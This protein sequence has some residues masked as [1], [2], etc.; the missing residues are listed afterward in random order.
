MIKNLTPS[1]L[2]SAALV[3][4][5][6]VWGVTFTVVD[7]ATDRLPAPD[8][9]VWR[10]G[11]AALVLRLVRRGRSSL[12]LLLRAR[13]VLLGVLLGAGFL[14]QAWALTY[15]DALRSGFLTGL[16]VVLAPVAAWL[17]FRERLGSATWAGVTLAAA[18]VGVLGFHA[19]GFGPGELLTLAS[20]AVWGL[21]LVLMSRWSE[22]EHAWGVARVQAAAVAALGGLVL[23]VRAARPG[24]STLL[25]LPTDGATWG[26]VLFLALVATAGT[27]VLLSWGQARVG[28]TRAAVILTLEPAVAGLTATIVGGAVTGRVLVG[29]VL[30][31]TAMLVVELA[32]RRGR[33][34]ADRSAG[35]VE[36]PRFVAPRPL[37]GGVG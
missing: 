29:G 26:S 8:L 13:S 3:A 19:G 28:A 9:V 4:V 7:G 30:L 34:A 31:L 21:H 37:A 11:L 2:P 23:V 32:G 10:F 5:A 36:A 12:P 16:L 18:G 33:A 27:M 15:T 17:V 22:A 35:P 24:P 20:A 25:V 6:V 1:R 14:L